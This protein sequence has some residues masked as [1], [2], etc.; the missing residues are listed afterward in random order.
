MCLPPPT[1]KKESAGSAVWAACAL[2]VS[3]VSWPLGLFWNY[4]KLWPRE[5]YAPEGNHPLGL[6]LGM[7]AVAWG[8]L[9]V[10]AYQYAR[11][12]GSTFFGELRRVQPNEKRDYE[13]SEGLMTHLAQPEGFVL[14]G[15]YLSLTWLFGKMPESYYH[16][17]GG[18]RFSRV[19]ACLLCQDAI[20]FAMHKLEHVAHSAF[21]RASHKPHH[22]FTNP[23]LFDAFNGSIAD[24]VC[25]I[26][27]PLYAT[28]NL[29]R[30]NVWEYMAFGTLYANWLVL[31]HSEF[32]HKW[33]PLFSTLS[34]GTAAD[35]H[36][37]HKLFVKNF[38][39]L[40]MFWDKLAGSYKDPTTVRVFAPL[41]GGGEGGVEKQHRN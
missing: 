9:F 1:K 22:R 35:H 12:R 27:V 33:D 24:T 37:H 11:H 10:L 4:E 40:F 34:F 16:F 23:R 5:W 19:F 2:W 14:L 28:A 7:A 21:Y 17:D 31:I 15:L 25:M 26:L 41:V 8:H 32:H 29:V 13:F 3:I 30:C 36:V 6:I 38:G 18:L 20:Q 39:H